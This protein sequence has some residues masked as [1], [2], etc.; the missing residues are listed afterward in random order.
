M[1]KADNSKTQLEVIRDASFLDAL[2]TTDNDENRF[3]YYARPILIELKNCI[4]PIAL[5]CVHKKLMQFF[6]LQTCMPLVS[7][8]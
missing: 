2:T 1:K 6:R 4:R 3:V 7:Q 5:A 8:L